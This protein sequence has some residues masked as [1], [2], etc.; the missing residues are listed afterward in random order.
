MGTLLVILESLVEETRLGWA[1]LA[2]RL[3][4][5][6]RTKA[7]HGVMPDH[8]DQLETTHFLHKLEFFPLQ[9]PVSGLLQRTFRHP[10]HQLRGISIPNLHFSASRSMQSMQSPSQ[11]AV[12]MI[13]AKTPL[14]LSMSCCLH[15][16]IHSSKEHL[17]ANECQIYAEN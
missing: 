15:Q 2:N 12:P 7:K 6:V 10:S 8:I 4:H 16:H 3:L 9:G 17:E 11:A 5:R 14:N 13:F 1:L